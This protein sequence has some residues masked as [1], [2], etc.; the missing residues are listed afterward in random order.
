MK[1]NMSQTASLVLKGAKELADRF[2]ND[3]IDV[4]HIFIALYTTHKGL[5][6]SVLLKNGIRAEDLHS[7]GTVLRFEARQVGH[8][9]VRG[10]YTERA[11]DVLDRAAAE[12]ER[13][14]MPEIGTEHILISILKDA[15]EDI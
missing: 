13:L 15:D 5:A 4:R 3:Y 11:R 6:Y 1:T 8:T 10:Q 9:K 2:D 14:K 12:A 7:L